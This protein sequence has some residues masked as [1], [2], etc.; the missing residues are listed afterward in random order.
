MRQHSRAL[1]EWARSHKV[2]ADPRAYTR[3][4]LPGLEQVQVV[5]IA[6]ATGLCAP[7]ASE[8]RK[9]RVPHPRHWETLRQLAHGA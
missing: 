3:D 9:G 4:I 2:P 5:A 6:R 8:I 7:Y 1:A